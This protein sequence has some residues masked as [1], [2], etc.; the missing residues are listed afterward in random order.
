MG[1]RW[2]RMTPR[3][4]LLKPM[5][6]HGQRGNRLFDNRPRRNGNGLCDYHTN[7]SQG[8]LAPSDPRR[9]QT[10]AEST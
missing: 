5:L 4:P 7:V 3:Q 8:F 2:W 1:R 6:E 9:T 10:G